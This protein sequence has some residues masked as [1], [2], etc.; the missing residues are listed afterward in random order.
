MRMKRCLRVNRSTRRCR[1]GRGFAPSARPTSMRLNVNAP[2][3]PARERAMLDHK[4]SILH[5][6]Y[7]GACQLLGD[8]VVAYAG[9]EPDRFG[10]RGE[11]VFEV[12]RHVLRAAEDVH[13]I[14]PAG[15]VRELSIDLAPEYLRRLG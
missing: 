14:N 13:H 15:H 8:G 3:A 2:S 7:P 10:S 4:T 1:R 11:Y 12:R 6:L 9:L 5:D